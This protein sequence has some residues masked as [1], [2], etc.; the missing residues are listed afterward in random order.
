V[1]GGQAAIPVETA[2][3]INFQNVTGDTK[4]VTNPDSNF[5]FNA[6]VAGAYCI[7]ASVM[8]NMGKADGHFRYLAIRVNGNIH[9]ESMSY[10]N[11]TLQCSFVVDLQPGDAITAVCAHHVREDFKDGKP[12]VPQLVKPVHGSFHAYLI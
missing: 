7:A 9:V 3:V 5:T 1:G 10:G 2:T 8:M 12:P 11:V 4:S 6:P